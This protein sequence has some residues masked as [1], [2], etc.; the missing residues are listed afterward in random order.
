MKLLRY[1]DK[2]RI[3]KEKKKLIDTRS[4]INEDFS[5]GTAEEENKTVRMSSRT[6]FP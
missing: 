3:L 6:F 1:N 5:R 4:Y 2:E